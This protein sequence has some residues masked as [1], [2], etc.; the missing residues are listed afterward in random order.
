MRPDRPNP[1]RDVLLGC[2]ACIAIVTLIAALQ[3]C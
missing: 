3:S 2:V 1:L